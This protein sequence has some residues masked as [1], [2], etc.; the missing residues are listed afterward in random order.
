MV[1]HL[2]ERDVPFAFGF[3]REAVARQRQQAVERAQQLVDLE[4]DDLSTEET[5]PSES[6][7]LDNFGAGRLG[8]AGVFDSSEDVDGFISDGVGDWN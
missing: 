4:A 1:L 6:D 7:K 2:P 3:E 8:D 5:S